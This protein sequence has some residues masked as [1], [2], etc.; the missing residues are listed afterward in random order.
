MTE[1]KA[2]LLILV[3]IVMLEAGLILGMAALGANNQ[4]LVFGLIIPMLV[5]AYLISRM[6]MHYGSE[7]DERER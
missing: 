7:A 2:F 6:V 5:G 4:Q 3:G 1:S